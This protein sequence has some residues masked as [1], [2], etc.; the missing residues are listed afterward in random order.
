MS[1]SHNKLPQ[2]KVSYRPDPSG[3]CQLSARDKADIT[4]LPTSEQN[5]WM[6]V[7]LYPSV[8][9][10]AVRTDKKRKPV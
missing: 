9:L 5:F 3:G 8:S 1:S 6:P 4:A 10:L 2:V 7:H